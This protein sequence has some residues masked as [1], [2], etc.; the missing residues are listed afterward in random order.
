MVREVRLRQRAR[1]RRFHNAHRGERCFIVGNG[2]SLNAVDLRRLQGERTFGVNGIYLK[3][4]EMGFEP[5][6]YIVED[7]LYMQQHA[8]RINQIDYAVRFFPERYIDLVPNP[9]ENTCFLLFDWSLYKPAS[10]GYREPRFS[11]DIERRVGTGGSVTFVALQVAFYMGFD[12]V[13][14]VG[15]DHNIVVPPTAEHV[16]RNRYRFAG[17]DPNHFR[18]DCG[19][20]T[21]VYLPQWDVVNR[22]FTRAR[23]AFECDGRRIYNATTGGKLELFERV[24]FGSLFS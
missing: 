8:E 6:Y 16:I 22:G 3:R 10:S 15:M 18:S 14:L 20:G 7:P 12:P 5:T 19:A 21:E 24:D 17:S 1:V 4:D 11:T 13:Y 23:D 9:G 2:P